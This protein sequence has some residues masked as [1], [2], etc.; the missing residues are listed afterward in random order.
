[1]RE[2]P[3]PTLP[4]ASLLESRRLPR[5]E[6]TV[7]AQ[8]RLQVSW[9]RTDEELR[10]AQR[11]RYRVFA[12]EMGARLSGPAGRDVDAFDAYC[13]HLLVRDLDTLKVVGTYRALPPHQAARIGRLYAESEFDV[14]RL[15]H[16]RAEMV[17]VGR[18]CVHA[19]YR[20][21]AVIMSLWA[22]LAAYMKHNGFET[23]LG[24]AGVARVDGGH[25]AADLHSALEESM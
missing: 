13:D 25:Y 18:S 21:G 9:A 17:E 16:L 24:C 20:S 8:H 3:T 7:T 5:A 10:E 2:L 1:M 6:E 23:M 4:F 15:T 12:E 22:G 14:S 19:D 11:L